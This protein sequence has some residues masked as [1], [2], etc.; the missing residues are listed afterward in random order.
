MAST[1]TNLIPDTYAALAVVAQEP[2][3]SLNIVTRDSNADR[4]AVNQTLRIPFSPDLSASDFT[5]AM[6]LPSASELTYTNVSLTMSKQRRVKFTWSG[7]DAY[8]VNRGPGFLTLQQ[9]NIAQAIRTLRNEMAAT[10]CTAASVSGSRAIGTAATTPF[11]SDFKHVNNIRKVLV[12]N[13]APVGGGWNLVVDT[14]AGTNLRN[15]ASLT[16]V[17]T[18]GSSDPLRRGVILPLSGGTVVEDANIQ[19]VTAGTGSGYLINEASGYAVGAT[20]L[21]LDTGTGTILAGDIIGI[22]NFDYVVASALASNVVTI[23]APGLREAVANNASVTVRATSARNFACTQDAILLATRL[24]EVGPQG[25]DLAIMREVITDPVSGLSFELSVYP[26]DHMAT[27]T[28][29]AVWGCSVV[30][31]RNLALLLG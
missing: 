12:D 14:A 22:G 10:V 26:G 29:G 30:N 28:I 9:Q 21:T 3:G 1:L 17:N 8:A 31:R 6:S 4:V 15:L 5:P 16:Q 23:A 13:G 19:T 11:A 25:T 7:E 18:A 27:Y 20:A 24:P 2:V